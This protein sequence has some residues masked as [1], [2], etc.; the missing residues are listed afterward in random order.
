M[1]WRL[2]NQPSTGVKRWGAQ[3]SQEGQLLVAFANIVKNIHQWHGWQAERT[4]SMFAADTKLRVWTVYPPFVLSKEQLHENIF[5]CVS[6]VLAEK[7]LL[8]Q[9]FS[10]VFT[11]HCNC[12]LVMLL[13]STW[14]KLFLHRWWNYC[15]FFASK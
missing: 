14:V 8:S 12:T 9:V 13:C 7:T 10:L 1:D 5:H 2:A 15:V 4:L 3:R 6:C 11:E